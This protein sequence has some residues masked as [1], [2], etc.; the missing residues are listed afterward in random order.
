VFSVAVLG[1]IRVGF[2]AWFLSP[3]SVIEG[4]FGVFYGLII[5]LFW[6]VISWCFDGLY[7][8]LEKMG[9]FWNW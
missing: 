8:W 9:C 6:V 1:W 3:V 4:W 7:W 5:P 2:G